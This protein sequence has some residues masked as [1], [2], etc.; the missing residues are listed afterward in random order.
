[1]PHLRYL[2]QT[3]FPRQGI[4]LKREDGTVVGKSQK[5]GMSALQ[6]VATSRI[7]TAIPVLTLVPFTLNA[8]MKTQVFGRIL[9]L[10]NFRDFVLFPFFNISKKMAR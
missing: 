1:M 10:I 9:Y 6:M 2:Y 3:K 4:K 7:V 5:A 8:L